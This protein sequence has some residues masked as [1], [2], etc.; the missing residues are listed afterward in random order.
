[1]VQQGEPSVRLAI[2][3]PAGRLERVF[4]PTDT[5]QDVYDYVECSEQVQHTF[6]HSHMHTQIHAHSHMHTHMHT[7]MYTSTHT[8][9]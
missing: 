5:L 1:M 2:R 4:A 6:T 8:Y 3:C 7:H 9:K